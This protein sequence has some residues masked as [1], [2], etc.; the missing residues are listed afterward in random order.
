MSDA[1]SNWLS[2]AF[3]RAPRVSAD[4]LHVCAA[5]G[6]DFVNPVEWEAVTPEAWWMILRCGECHTFREVTVTNQVAER[7]DIELDRR[8]DPIHRALAKLDRERMVQQV[9]TMIGALRRG[10][11][12]PADFGP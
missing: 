11:I 8:Q 10:L 3:G 4:N 7:F 1:G 5:C 6:K 12:E 2:R 9:E